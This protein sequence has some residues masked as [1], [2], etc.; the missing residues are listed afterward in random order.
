[1]TNEECLDKAL[2]YT[3]TMN[4]CCCHVN[5]CVFTG[6]CKFDE[7]V[8]DCE[9]YT[10]FKRIKSALEREPV[11][12]GKWKQWDSYGYEDTYECTECGEA[13]VLIE[14]TPITNEYKYCPN[15]GAK[16]D[17]VEE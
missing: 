4:N 8:S 7:D 16:M 11:R 15:C 10:V 14:G 5:T 17:E 3:S 6:E 2:E 12:H 13:F 9:E 1:M